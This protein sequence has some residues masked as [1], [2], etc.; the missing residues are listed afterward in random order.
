MLRRATAGDGPLLRTATASDWKALTGLEA[1]G[2]WIGLA[3]EEDGALLGLGA[4][5]EGVDGRWWSSVAANAR[6]P[7]ALWKAAREVLETAAAA[8][9]D[10]HAMAAPWIDGADKFLLRLGFVATD[11]MIEGHRVYRWTL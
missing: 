8:G 7:V 9:I 1:P 11:E 10:V 6:R 3:Y 5:Y 2:Y 4:L